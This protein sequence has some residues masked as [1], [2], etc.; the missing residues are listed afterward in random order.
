MSLLS[1]GGCRP[2]CSESGAQP[3]NTRIPG[4]WRTARPCSP[5]EQAERPMSQMTINTS[6]DKETLSSLTGMGEPAFPFTKNWFTSSLFIQHVAPNYIT[7]KIYC[8][9][10]SSSKQIYWVQRPWQASK[11]VSLILDHMRLSWRRGLNTYTKG[12]AA[13]QAH[14]RRAVHGATAGTDPKATGKQR[15]PVFKCTIIGDRPLILT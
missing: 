1:A 7:L 6:W 12:L 10:I 11:L 14:S 13:C 3:G 8:L 5:Q 2:H 15:Q 9:D 4:S